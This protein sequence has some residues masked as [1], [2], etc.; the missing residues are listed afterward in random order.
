M[1]YEYPSEDAVPVKDLSAEAS[2]FEKGLVSESREEVNRL[3]A[4]IHDSELGGRIKS[5][6]GVHLPRLE[7]VPLIAFSKNARGVADDAMTRL[8]ADRMNFRSLSNPDIIGVEGG[9]CLEYSAVAEAA[10]HLMYSGTKEK[11]P[12]DGR[13]S[14]LLFRLYD[15]V[16]G[17]L[18]AYHAVLGVTAIYRDTGRVETRVIDALNGIECSY[19]DFMSGAEFSDR[20]KRPEALIGV[21]TSN[22]MIHL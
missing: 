18:G 16:Q 15:K 8:P 1:S 22:E 6:V 10:F 21:I 13:T 12:F 4:L 7:D 14:I 17:K 3:Y 5:G 11:P 19:D 20:E 2:R 9:L